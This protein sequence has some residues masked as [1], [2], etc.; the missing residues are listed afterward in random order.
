MADDRELLFSKTSRILPG[1]ER[2][3]IMK[4]W[5]ILVST[6]WG[7]ERK[8]LRFLSQHGEFKSSGFKDLL[9]GHVENVNLFLDKLEL[10]RQENPNRINSLSQIVPL[11]RTFYFEL[12]DFMEK[13][14]QIVL[15]YAGR[16]ED[17]KFYVRV[18]RRG[19][20][21]EMSSQEIEKEV[22]GFVIEKLEKAG[23]DAQVSFG[24]PD[25][26]L[27]VETI[28]NWAGVTLITREMKEKYPLVKVK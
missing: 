2:R 18:K 12:P 17:K 4:E 13:L 16:I 28:A 6:H 8:S 26:I 21:G 22:A 9:Q 1:R 10:M 25:V 23:K 3:I 11:E 14:K 7:Q 19:H 15:P 20:K 27:V 24:D 5:N